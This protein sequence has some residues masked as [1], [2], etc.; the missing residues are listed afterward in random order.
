MTAGESANVS[1]RFAPSPTGPLHLGSLMAAVASFLDAHHRSGRWLVRVDDLDTPRKRPGA[2]RTILRTLEQHGLWWNGEVD[3]QSEHQDRYQQA[4][5]DLERRGLL[6]YCRCSRTRLKSHPIYP[7]TCR[8]HKAYRA[9]AARRILTQGAICHFVDGIQGPVSTRIDQ[10]IGDFIVVRRDGQIAY[11]LATAVDD[12]APGITHV[13]R[14]R[15]LLELTAAQMFLMTKLKLKAPEYLHIPVLVGSDGHK[16]SKQSKAPPLRPERAGSN[17]IA[18]L[19]LLGQRVDD[20][21]Q[22]LDPS[23]ILSTA[24]PRWDIDRV[25]KV[26]ALTR[27]GTTPENPRLL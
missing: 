10:E 17:L 6:F 20:L 21:N 13:V 9:D 22:E 14:G 4:V 27:S 19:G 8:H 7:G 25:P 2:I 15:D 23:T 5:A 12:G 3:Y 11:Q 1:G 16:L 24:A 26:A 18:V